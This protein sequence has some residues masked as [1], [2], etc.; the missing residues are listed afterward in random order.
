MLQRAGGVWQEVLPARAVLLQSR[1]GNLLHEGCRLLQRRTGRK[2]QGPMDVLSAGH[3]LRADDPSQPGRGDVRLA[4]R[5][6]PGQSGRTAERVEGVLSSRPGVA[7][8]QARRRRRRRRRSLL[9]CRERVR[10][11]HEHHVLLERS[12][13]RTSLLRRR[14][15]Q[16]E[17]RPEQLRRLREDVPAG[18]ALRERRLPT[19]VGA[20]AQLRGGTLED[21]AVRGVGGSVWGRCQ[22][23][24]SALR[25]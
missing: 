18:P 1:A 23:G 14:L 11:R 4:P 12:R 9:R 2:Q 10:L 17:A 19:C 21:L 25:V 13:A 16:R 5:L 22:G 15:R 24:A 20:R 6:L 8:R 3:R 7:R